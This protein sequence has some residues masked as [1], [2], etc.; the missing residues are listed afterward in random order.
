ML[1]IIILIAALLAVIFAAE[2][3]RNRKRPYGSASGKSNRQ[4]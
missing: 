1:P 2:H 3:F 4:K